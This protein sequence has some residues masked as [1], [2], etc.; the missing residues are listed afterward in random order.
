MSVSSSARHSYI[1][2]CAAVAPPP[3]SCIPISDGPVDPLALYTLAQLKSIATKIEELL[4]HWRPC[5]HR[6]DDGAIRPSECV[7]GSHEPTTCPEH[8][9]E[10]SN[11]ATRPAG[12]DSP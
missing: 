8:G 11:T 5:S 6:D 4:R 12:P 10:H 3:P 2:Y 1:P 9:H 7:N